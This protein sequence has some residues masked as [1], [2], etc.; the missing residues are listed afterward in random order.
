M[1]HAHDT[2]MNPNYKS[3]LLCQILLVGSPT[4]TQ[5]MSLKQITTV[6]YFTSICILHSASDI[7]RLQDYYI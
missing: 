5:I 1:Q 3:N 2:C 6:P 7:T 4:F